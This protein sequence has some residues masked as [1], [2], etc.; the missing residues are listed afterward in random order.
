MAAEVKL[1]IAAQVVNGGE[2]RAG[3]HCPGDIWNDPL[4]AASAVLQRRNR[5][6]R[7]DCGASHSFPMSELGPLGSTLAL[8]WGERVLTIGASSLPRGL[9]G[10]KVLTEGSLL[11][12]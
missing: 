2:G 6:R 10:E 1:E 5:V 7:A 12:S 9:Q 8:S 3:D 11:L 4:V